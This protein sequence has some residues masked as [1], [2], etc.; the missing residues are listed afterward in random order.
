M[1]AKGRHPEDENDFNQKL[2][3]IISTF[4]SDLASEHPTVQFACAGF[5]PDHELLDRADVLIESKYLRRSTTPGKIRDPISADLTNTPPGKHLLVIVFDPE[6]AIVD[7]DTFKL[8]FES[9]G[10]CTVRIIS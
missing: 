8:D 3:A 6:D 4:R 10:R 1:F 2:A 5:T 9:R 7:R